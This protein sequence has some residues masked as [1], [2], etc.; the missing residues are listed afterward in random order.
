ME[1][2]DAPSRAPLTLFRMNTQQDIEQFAT[3]CDADIGG[4]STVHLELDQSPERNKGSGSSATGRFWG[5]M[6]LQVRPELQ[7]RIRGGYAGFRSKVNVSLIQCNAG[8]LLT[9][10]FTQRP[11]LATPDALW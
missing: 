11:V 1:G 3:G 8:L 5:E 9:P 2:A 6:R 7:G 10:R 4:T